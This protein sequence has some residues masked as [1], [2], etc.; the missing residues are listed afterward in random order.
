MS[1]QGVPSSNPY[2]S[3]RGRLRQRRDG[4]SQS[5]LGARITL[6]FV[7][8]TAFGAGVWALSPWLTGKAEPWDASLPVYCLCMLLGGF[9][10]AMLCPRLFWI[11]VL[12]IYLGQVTYYFLFIGSPGATVVLL[13]LSV[14]VFGIPP[15]FV[16]AIMA[17]ACS[18]L[19]RSF[20]RESTRPN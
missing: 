16:G 12:G 11:A 7:V 1:I 18:L 9:V 20:R 14:A 4:P 10:F 5:A 13:L 6:S 19:W 17:C 15:A 8:A 2:E 3:P